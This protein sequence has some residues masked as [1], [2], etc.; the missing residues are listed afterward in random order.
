MGITETASPLLS[1]PIDPKLHKL[2]SPGIAYGNEVRIAM[3]MG[4]FC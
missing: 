3:L 1:N 4:K 2:G